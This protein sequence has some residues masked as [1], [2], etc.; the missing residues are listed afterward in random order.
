[1]NNPTPGRIVM[2]VSKNGDGIESPAIVLRTRATT[3]LD[4][5][6]RW[7]PTSPD[8]TLSGKERPAALV[9]E[10]PDDNTVDLLVWGLGGDYREYCIPA[11]APDEETGAY[12]PGTWHWP[13]YK[14]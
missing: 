10:L 12:Y 9:P 6:E 7:S 5:I 8:G 4:I 3:N 2:Y 11:S 14:G 1:M 13:I